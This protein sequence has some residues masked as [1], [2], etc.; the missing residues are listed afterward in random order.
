MKKN[1]VVGLEGI[2]TRKLTQIIREHGTLKGVIHTKIGPNLDNFDGL[3]SEFVFNNL[4]YQVCRN[5]MLIIG[6]EK[7][8]DQRIL[9]IDCGIKNNQLRM[10][11]NNGANT[12]YVIGIGETL[13]FF[14]KKNRLILM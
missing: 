11:I 3:A 4:A 2:D 12:L 1:N 13:T 5:D 7:E 9:V 10:L 6:D 14:F 8:R